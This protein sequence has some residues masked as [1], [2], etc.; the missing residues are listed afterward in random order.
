MARFELVLSLAKRNDDNE[1]YTEETEY[2]C[3][4]KNLKD[5]EEITDTANEVIKEEIGESEEGEVLFGSAD[6]IINNLTVLMLQYTNSELPRDEMDEII[7]LLTE[8]QGAMH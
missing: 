1:L 4:C 7:D 6:V 8:P 5:L 2:V 3:F